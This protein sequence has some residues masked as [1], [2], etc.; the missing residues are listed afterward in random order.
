MC[1]CFNIF[2][3]LL[4]AD[5][6]LMFSCNLGWLLQ[7][8]SSSPRNRQLTATILRQTFKKAGHVERLHLTYW[9]WIL[10]KKQKYRKHL[11]WGRFYGLTVQ[12]QCPCLKMLNKCGLFHHSFKCTLLCYCLKSSKCH[13]AMQYWIIWELHIIAVYCDVVVNTHYTPWN[14]QWVPC[15]AV[16]AKYFSVAK[17]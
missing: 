16:S 17:R 6:I 1:H 15:C 14:L 7:H 5:I 9:R 11:E 4:A 3:Q 8:T 13:Q 12:A 10:S 2:L